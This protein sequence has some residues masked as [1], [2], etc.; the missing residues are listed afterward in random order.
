MATTKTKTYPIRGF[1][2]T[3]SADT[4]GRSLGRMDGVIMAAADYDHALL[5]Q[6]AGRRLLPTPRVHDD[7]RPSPPSRP[8][9]ER[10]RSRP[11][12][13]IRI[14]ERISADSGRSQIWADPHQ[15]LRF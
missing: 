3:G 7:I 14:V 4:L 15:P 5:E 10:H 11:C 2:C 6:P 12:P 8:E 9:D 1:H 13:Q